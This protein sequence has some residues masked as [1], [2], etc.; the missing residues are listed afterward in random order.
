[1]VISFDRHDLFV[2]Q[3]SRGRGRWSVADMVCGRYRTDPQ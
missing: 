1:M 2:W 3:M